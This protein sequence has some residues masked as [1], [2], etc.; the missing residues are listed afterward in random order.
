MSQIKNNGYQFLEWDSNFLKLKVCK[1]ISTEINLTKSILEEI[2][3]NDFDLVYLSSAEKIN[4]E[5][6]FIQNFEIR[7]VDIKTTYL[8][9]NLIQS[10]DSNHN[11]TYTASIPE[12]KLIEL[13]LESGMYSRFKVDSN[14]P[15][16]KFEELYT[17]WITNSVNKQIADE[18]IVN[19]QNNEISG[20]ITLGIKNMIGDIGI[21]AVDS[22]YRG[23]KIGK[24][25]I[26]SAENYFLNQGIDSIQVVTQGVNLP[27]C[28][29]Y[30][31]C[32]YTISEENYFYHLWRK[33]Q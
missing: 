8:K 24:S 23:Q 7:L 25:L 19:Y 11:K 13:A 3:K 33:N 5:T 15:E 20:F 26:Y 27:A 17:L 2:Y 14:I 28:N 4:F 12:K 10:P 6:N 30:A 18:V 9:S 21:I 16:A 1:I 29:L 22:K 32:G 31:S